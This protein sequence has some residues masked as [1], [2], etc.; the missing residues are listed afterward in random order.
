MRNF[1][2]LRIWQKGIDIAVKTFQYAETLPKEDK[3]GISQ[4]MKR[5]GVSIPAILLKEAAVKVKKIMQGLLK[6][7]WAH[8]LNWKLN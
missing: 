3:F 8:H 7:L 1:K 6:Y 2:V 4:Q 5:A